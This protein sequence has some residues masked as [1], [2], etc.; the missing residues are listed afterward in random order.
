VPTDGD[1]LTQLAST[2]AARRGK[3]SDPEDVK[4][5]K[6]SERVVLDE[7][8]AIDVTV[9]ILVK[10]GKPGAIAGVTLKMG[11][12]ADR[13]ALVTEADGVAKELEAAIQA[14]AKPLW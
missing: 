5:M 9:P 4:A 10:D 11:S 13:E 1:E 14:A 8:G 7:E 6:S 3:P 12:D 2:M